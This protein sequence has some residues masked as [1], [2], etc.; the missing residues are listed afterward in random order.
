MPDAKTHDAIAMAS[1]LILAPAAY[2]TLQ[3]YGDTPAQAFSGAAFVVVAHLVGSFWLSPDLDL[4][5]A[6]DDRWGPFFWLW[7]PYMWM[8]P[9]RHRILSHSGFS[10]LLRLGY[11]Y[12][13]IGGLLFIG[14]IA[15][16]SLGIVQSQ[17]YY[18][19]FEGWVVGL[20]R[21]HPR[22]AWLVAVGAVISDLV[23]SIADHL[24]THQRRLL[25]ALGIRVR[26]SYRNHS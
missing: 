8:V 9:H 16:T 5:S 18:Q 13:V 23:H 2:A 10:A 14:G 26:R 22:E 25:R 4:D 21:E 20:I 1:S 6:I 19:I 15:L 12:V 7:R 11:L 24:V 17:S 3:Y